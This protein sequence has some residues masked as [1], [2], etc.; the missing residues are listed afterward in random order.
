MSDAVTI[1]L[2]NGAFTLAGTLIT[3]AA[4]VVSRW[5]S[6]RENHNTSSKLDDIH[7]ET[8]SMKDAL[9]A[10]TEKEA[11]ARGGAEERQR[12]EKREKP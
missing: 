7:R 2:V 8:N 4:I 9:V 3:V 10:A 5:L 6:S 11:L 12:A 1:A